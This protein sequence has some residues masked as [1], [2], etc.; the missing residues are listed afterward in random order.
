NS[1]EITCSTSNEAVATVASEGTVTAVG[2]GVTV[3]SAVP[4]DR[5][6]TRSTY[7]VNVIQP[8]KKITLSATKLSHAK[9]SK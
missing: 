5:V 1:T 9:G 4:S 3:I 6:G 8:L 2:R 7:V